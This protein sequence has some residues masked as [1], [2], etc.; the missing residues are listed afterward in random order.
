MIANNLPNTSNPGRPK[1]DYVNLG[2]LCLS[3][4]GVRALP[5][6]LNG[7]LFDD[8]AGVRLLRPPAG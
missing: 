5:R 7:Q 1:I 6:V 2:C 4:G 3:A 8:Q